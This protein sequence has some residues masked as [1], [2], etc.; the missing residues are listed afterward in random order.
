MF[1]F[2]KWFKK[3]MKLRIK[4][5]H[6]SVSLIGAL[7]NDTKGNGDHI[8]S[9]GLFQSAERRWEKMLVKG[10]SDVASEMASLCY[11]EIVG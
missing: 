7:T 5:K 6:L 8:N 9:R 3:A 1:P 11:G 2:R 10:R 4:G